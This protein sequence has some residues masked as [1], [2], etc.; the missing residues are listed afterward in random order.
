MST[1]TRVTRQDRLAV[2]LHDKAATLP[3]PADDTAGGAME[4][5]RQGAYS[6]DIAAVRVARHADS[7]NATT[8][9]TG[10]VQLAGMDAA[11]GWA[12]LAT[13]NA[14]DDISLTADLGYEE[15]FHD[16][17]GFARLALVAAGVSAT[18]FAHVTAIPYEHLQ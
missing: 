5:W 18:D 2:V 15:R 12:V 11:G 3:E 13:L 1:N 8:V 10:P 9:I 7:I 17:G 4:A 6:P 16:V 14:G